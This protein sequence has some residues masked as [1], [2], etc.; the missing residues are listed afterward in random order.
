MFKKLLDKIY[1]LFEITSNHFPF[2]ASMYIYF[3]KYS[4]FKEIKMS[5]LEKNENILH[6]GCGAIPYTT[7]I[8]AE[9]LKCNVVGIDKYEDV[10]INANKLLKR[11]GL[12]D[13]INLKQGDGENYDITNYDAVIISYGIGN[14]DIVLKNVISKAKTNTKI[15]LRRSITDTNQYLIDMIQK[16]SIKKERSLLTEESILFIKE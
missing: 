12:Q 5:K 15:I 1:F 3:H 7:I 8:L 6:I 13:K 10:I 16:K 4:V 9:K 11:M 14:T 2:F